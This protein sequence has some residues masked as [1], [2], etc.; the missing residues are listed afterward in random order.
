MLTARRMR[1]IKSV[2]I[3]QKVLH[4]KYDQLRR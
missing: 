4:Y 3:V 1:T 2:R